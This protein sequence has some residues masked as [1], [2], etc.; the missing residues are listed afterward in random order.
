MVGG[1]VG[2]GEVG[3]EFP[4]LADGDGGSA[5]EVGLDEE[6]EREDRV[7]GEREVGQGSQGNVEAELRLARLQH[8]SASKSKLI[9]GCGRLAFSK[10]VVISKAPSV[11]SRTAVSSC[12]GKL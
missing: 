5:Q 11:A 12:P 4:L 3:A 8:M 9:E 1:S 6:G 7:W 2:G 10:R